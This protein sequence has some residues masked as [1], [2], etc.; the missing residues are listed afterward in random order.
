MVGTGSGGDGPMFHNFLGVMG[1]F[2]GVSD[3]R[4]F[5]IVMNGRAERVE[6]DSMSAISQVFL[7]ICS[8]I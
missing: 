1:W 8:Y 6:R 7:P 5:L 4:N 2:L 3:M